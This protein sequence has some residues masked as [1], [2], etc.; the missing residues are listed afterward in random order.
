MK[1]YYYD[2]LLNIKT[3]DHKNAYTNGNTIHY[4]PYEP[5][6]YDVLELL[7]TIYPVKQTDYIVDF[8][9]GLGRLNF[10][11]HY[12]YHSSIIGIER[13]E[14]FYKKAIDNKNHYMAKTK[15]KS[16]KMFFLNCLAEEY[17][18]KKE[19]NRF[20]FFNPFSINIFRKVVKNILVS[21]E[22]KKR[23][24]DIILYYPHDDYV[25][26]LENETL[27]ELI[28]EIKIPKMYDKDPYER[29]LIYRLNKC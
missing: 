7:F 28:S 23:E 27:F 15:R 16:D 18:I 25:F 6:P 8:G 24:V 5:T 13:N 11:I 20:Y 17:E 29:I 14:E 26:F 1:E 4:H 19:D 21:F 12:F 2:K 22:Q 3:Q 10:Y 9:C